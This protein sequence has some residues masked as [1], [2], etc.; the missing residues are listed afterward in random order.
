MQ[1]PKKIMMVILA[2]GMINT[3]LQAQFLKKLKEK[4]NNA[5][6]KNINNNSNS[7]SSQVPNGNASNGKPT[8]TKG[9]G[10]TN[11]TPPDVNQQIADA[12]QAQASGNYSDA[13]YSIQQALMGIELQIGKQILLSLPESVSGLQKD[14]MQNKVMSTRW[15]WNNMTIQSVYKKDDKQMTVTIGNNGVYSGFVNMYFN[16][17]YQQTSENGDK[18]NVK[19]TKVKGYKALI[20][21][22]DS[23]GY[24]LMVPIGQSSLIVWEC[25]NFG[26]EAEVMSAAN[27]F[28]IDGIKKMLGEQ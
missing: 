19:Q 25:I 17:A 3:G 12:T 21:Y 23:K 22:D 16:S 2:A 5:V 8:N 20:T 4:V 26:T 1:L 15:G 24:T 10:L 18:Q 6:N 14:T 28:D 27:V 11:T 7:N 9:G 13:R